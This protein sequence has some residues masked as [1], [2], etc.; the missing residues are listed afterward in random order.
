MN[1]KSGFT[2][3]E[4]L[5]VIVVIAI[6]AAI[7]IVA[8]NGISKSAQ[9]ASLKSDLHSASTSLE[10]YKQLQDG[11]PDALSSVNDG[12]GIKPSGGN[13]FSYFKLSDGYCVQASRN[14]GLSFFFASLSGSITKGT[15][16]QVASLDVKNLGGK[17]IAG[18]ASHDLTTLVQDEG[19]FGIKN[20]MVST[21]VDFVQSPNF[22]VDYLTAAES[23]GATLLISLEP[24]NWSAPANQQ[25]TFAPRVI[26]GGG[27]DA[28]ITSW[29]QEAQQYAHKAQIIVRFAPEMNDTARSW[30]PGIG[31]VG[32]SE[33]T[34]AEY[35]AMWRH[36][37]AIRDAVAPDVLLMW[38]PLNYGAGSYQFESFYPGDAYVD[39]LGLDGF[40]WSDQRAGSPGWQD[41]TAV[42]GFDDPTNGPVPRIKTLA[43]SKPWG[44][45][46]T[47]SAPD[48]PAYFQS[49]G[50]YYTSY[51]SW[52]FDWP[53]NPPYESTASD[54]IT[55]EG[56]TRMLIRRAYNSGASFV[57]LFH[58]NKETDWRLTDTAPGKSVFTDSQAWNNKITGGLR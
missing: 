38:N 58:T 54:W 49:G 24:W 33:A 30:S 46:E 22:P 37:A 21:Y 20:G 19:N 50:K 40:N 12:L 5:I 26:A 57:D 42:F 32:Y 7:T 23:R 11:Y 34:P 31:T 47:A 29:F 8:Y 14:N 10:V 43:G 56:W 51:G 36:V 55:Q 35:I 16:S 39:V 6:L 41:S 17:M 28:H 44:I 27:Q 25:P 45:A 4:L 15:C 13:T 9:E 18:W 48:V 53:N 3:V 1:R 52:V 2:I